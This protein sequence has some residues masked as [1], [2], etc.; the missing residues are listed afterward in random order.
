MVREGEPTSNRA[1]KLR[2]FPTE[3]QKKMML[4]NMNVAKFSYNWA[5]KV[6]LQEYEA[7]DVASKEYRESLSKDLSE[8]QVEKTMTSFRKQYMKENIHTARQI[9][10]LF[11]TDIKANPDNYAWFGKFDSYARHYTITLC[12]ENALKKFFRDL[13]KNKERVKNAKKKCVRNGKN[14]IFSYPKDYGFP[15]YR[16]KS[17]SKSYPTVVSKSKLDRDRCKVYIPVVGW[18]RFSKNQDIPEFQYPSQDLGNCSISTDGKD[19]YLS[20]G[21]YQPFE[22]YYTED[23]PILG[24]DLGVKN[25]ATL[26]DGTLI[27][28]VANN[29]KVIKLNNKIKKLQRKL[30]WLREHSEPIWRRKQE[31]SESEWKKEQWKIETRQTRRIQERIT[32]AYIAL[33]NYKDNL[34]HNQCSEIIK[35]NPKGIVFENLNVKGMQKNKKLSSKLQQTGMYKF[36]VTL[37][38]HAKK[39][40]IKVKQ[41]D[42]FYPSSQICSNCGYQHIDMKDLSKRVFECPH[43]GMK[44]NRD[45]NAARNLQEQWDNPNIEFI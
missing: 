39:H 44:L 25:V 43:C 32:K 26:S 10:A 9:N 29:P 23:T 6:N 16:D 4:H 22:P 40:N 19:F 30:C 3:K 1:I 37:K 27:P 5:R 38:W 18:V 11:T 8:E 28:N 45:I 36:K 7:F 17:H 13:A 20:F 33:D 31:I 35:K 12:Y 42:R 41:V 21:Y 34:L 2:L 15:Q 24:V 14:K